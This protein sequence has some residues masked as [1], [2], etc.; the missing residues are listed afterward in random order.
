LRELLRLLALELLL[1]HVLLIHELLEVRIV[2]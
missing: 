2:H 1:A